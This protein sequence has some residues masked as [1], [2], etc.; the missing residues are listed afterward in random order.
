MG[1][2]ETFKTLVSCT[3]EGFCAS[4]HA[5][6]N[7]EGSLKEPDAVATTRAETSSWATPVTTGCWSST[8]NAN[9][10][11]QFGS[12]GSGE[13]QFQG[14]A[15]HHRQRLG[16]YVCL[17]GDRIQEFSPTGAYLRQFGSPGSGDGQFAGPS[18]IAIDSAAMCGCSTASTTA[19]RSSPPRAH[20]SGSSARRARAMAS[21][22][23]P[24]DSPSRAATCMSRNS[25]TRG[26]RSSQPRAPTSGSSA[27]AARATVSSTGHGASPQTPTAATSTSQTPPTA[28]S[29]SSA[30]RAPS[31]RRSA[32]R[33]PVGP[34][35]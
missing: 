20:T 21:S 7:I 32:P 31:S 12:A 5:P 33:A 26:C 16:G 35:V 34:A 1:S 19:S 29:R 25:P 18:A 11:A 10:S 2:D 13:G 23:G 3:P 24:S 17:K 9:T 14:I 8:P 4:S 27:S 15:G 6:A 28:A 22:G 30:P